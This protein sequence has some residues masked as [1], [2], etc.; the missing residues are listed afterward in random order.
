MHGL[1]WILLWMKQLQGT[2]LG[3]LGKYKY[4]MGVRS[5]EILLK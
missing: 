5:V 3:H 2:F 4:D 1:D